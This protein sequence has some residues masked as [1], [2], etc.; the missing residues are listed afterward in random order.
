[1]PYNISEILGVEFATLSLS[2]KI[3][4]VKNSQEILKLSKINSG[5][6]SIEEID[7]EAALIKKSAIAKIKDLLDKTTY[8][9][10]SIN[11]LDMK[12]INLA[13]IYEKTGKYVSMDIWTS[14][15]THGAISEY[16]SWLSNNISK[17][18]FH[19]DSQIN[20]SIKNALTHYMEKSKSLGETH[21]FGYQEGLYAIDTKTG[22]YKEDTASIGK[23]AGAIIE[24]LDTSGRLNLLKTRGKKTFV[25]ENIEVVSDYAPL[26]ASHRIAEKPVSVVLVPQKEGYVGGSPFLI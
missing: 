9:P 23:G 22:N 24:Y 6:M 21:L 8:N 18:T 11:T 26:F 3:V 2:G 4:A 1:V 10:K 13:T 14:E 12:F 19:P 16:L 15:Q 5:K 20:D 7:K 25:F 17:K